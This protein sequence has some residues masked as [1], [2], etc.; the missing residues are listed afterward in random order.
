MILRRGTFVDQ[1]RIISHT[2]NHQTSLLADAVNIASIQGIQR[3]IFSVEDENSELDTGRT[4][5]Q[6]LILTVPNKGLNHYLDLQTETNP[7]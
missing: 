7:N 5:V 3:F 1:R 4:S 2:A 6:D